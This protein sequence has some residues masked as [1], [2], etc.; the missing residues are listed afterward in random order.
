MNN[1]VAGRLEL[2]ISGDIGIKGLDGKYP[3]GAFAQAAHAAIDHAVEV[4]GGLAYHSDGDTWLDLN[5][6]GGDHAAAV[7]AITT[8]LAIEGFPVLVV[9]VRECPA[10]EHMETRDPKC[11]TCGGEGTVDNRAF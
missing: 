7:G 8:Y 9:D 1:S 2:W 11:P 4:A 3:E 6:D 10:C 5:S